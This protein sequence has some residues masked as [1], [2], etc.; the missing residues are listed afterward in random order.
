MQDLTRL[1]LLIYKQK[2][3]D[4]TVISHL[5]AEAIIEMLGITDQTVITEFTKLMEELDG[6]ISTN[7]SC[8]L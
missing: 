4:E 8:M 7:I 2:S 1:M 6:L 3:K 5:T